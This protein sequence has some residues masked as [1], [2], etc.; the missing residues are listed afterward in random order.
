MFKDLMV[1]LD[2]GERTSARLELAA[3]LA[4][5]HKARLTGVFGQRAEAVQVGVIASWPPEEYTRSAGVVRARFEQAAEDLGQHEWHDINRGGD[6]ELLRQ[7]VDYARY[8]DLMILG[9]HDESSHA[10][11]PRGGLF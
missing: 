8:G 2:E 1:H 7:I 10:F 3:T 5:R 9:Q 6:A 4:R 11:V